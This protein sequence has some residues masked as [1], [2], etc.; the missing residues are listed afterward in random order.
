MALYK[1]A[2]YHYYNYYYYYIINK[3]IERQNRETKLGRWSVAACRRVLR[4]SRSKTENA[5]GFANRDKPV[6]FQFQRRR[7]RVFSPH[8]S[9]YWHCLHSMRSGV[10]VTV[11][12][13]SVRPSV[14]AWAHSSKPL[15]QVCCSGI[16]AGEC[17]R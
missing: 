12:C 9:I 6:Y 4:M 2:Y 8:L 16:A 17:G 13:P 10:Y 5:R 11:R 1:C 3:S 7:T 14:P 15:L